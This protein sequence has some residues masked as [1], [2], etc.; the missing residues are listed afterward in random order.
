MGKGRE[1]K[2]EEIGERRE[3]LEILLHRLEGDRHC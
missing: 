2:E 3:G 1:E